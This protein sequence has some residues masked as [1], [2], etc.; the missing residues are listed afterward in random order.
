MT[1]TSSRS[2][3]PLEKG[4]DRAAVACP[5]GCLAIGSLRK[6]QMKDG[7]CHV[8]GCACIRCRNARNRA[9]GHTAQNTARKLLG[10]PQARYRGQEAN[11][12]QW[13]DE[14]WR[15]EVKSGN[16][17][18]PA[19]TAFFK[20]EKQ[21]DAS[22]AIG[23]TR[24]VAVTFMASKYGGEGVTAFRTSVYATYIKPALDAHYGSSADA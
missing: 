22:K 17:V 21:A 23:D 10:V 3:G 9:G 4:D 11:E 15:H 20:A 6:K 7:K 12:E 16:Q 19:A 14:H 24:P 8:R 5:C 2:T 1:Y 18:A 13:R